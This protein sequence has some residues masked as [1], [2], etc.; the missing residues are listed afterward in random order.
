MNLFSGPRCRPDALAG[1]RYWHLNE[2]LS[3]DEYTQVNANRPGVR[4]HNIHVADYFATDNSF[5]G[6]HLTCGQFQLNRLT[7]EF[8]T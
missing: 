1:F 8:T 2:D 7:A 6:G 3:I 4:G 5:Y